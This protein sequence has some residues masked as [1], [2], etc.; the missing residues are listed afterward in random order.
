MFR[1]LLLTCCLLAIA[2]AKDAEVGEL[3]V[4][5]LL[6]KKETVKSSGSFLS[7]VQRDVI[8]KGVSSMPRHVQITDMY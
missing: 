5:D 7:N 2:V 1:T 4:G 8:Y 6:L 3:L